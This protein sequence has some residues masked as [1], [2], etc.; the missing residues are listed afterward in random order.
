M[1]LNP[2]G[3]KREAREREGGEVSGET[4]ESAGLKMEERGER[5]RVREIQRDGEGKGHAKNI[6]G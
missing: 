2:G 6:K 5:G 3:K 1:Y 4:G